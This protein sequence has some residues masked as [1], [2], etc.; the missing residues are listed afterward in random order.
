MV[1]TVELLR[2][3]GSPFAESTEHSLSRSKF[4]K[5]YNCAQKNRILY[6]Y[7]HT[8]CR[9]NMINFAIPFEREKARYLKT[10]DVIT[11]ASQVLAS[12]KIDHAIFKT[13]RPYESTT[14]DVDIIIFGGKD[15]YL[16]SI[17]VMQ[18]AGYKKGVV[19][20]Q[21]TTLRDYETGLGID[22]YEN[23][24]VGF[25]TYMDKRN[26]VK[27]TT[28]VHM[29]NGLSVR[30]L[31]PHADLVAVIAHSIMKEQM[32]TLSE[33]YTF[34]EYLKS[35]NI[36]ELEET[37]KENHVIHP[38]KVHASITALLHDAAHGF[39]PNKILHILDTIGEDTLEKARITKRNFRTPHKY[40]LVTVSRSLLEIT[41]GEKSRNSI[42]TQIV[43]TFHPKIAKDL[44][45]KLL[46]HVTRETY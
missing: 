36:E 35:I 42:A 38:T 18:K 41:K 43:H 44:V 46:K 30:T 39:I 14:V 5:F 31:K 11:K 32:Y 8:V 10:V 26:L 6:L 17:E 4:E 24:A 3:I 15:D 1:Q 40:H 19:G 27:H 29:P 25:V 21:S 34:L 12:V 33:Y 9:R 28:T 13:I 16:N 37:A 23:V 45:S 22:L 2:L 7:L 20:P